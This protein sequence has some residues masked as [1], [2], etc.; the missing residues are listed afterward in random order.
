MRMRL[1]ALTT[2]SNLLARLH[3]Q[4]FAQAW[5]AESFSVLLAEAAT[6]AIFCGDGFILV[7]VVEGEAELLSLGVTPAARRRGIGAALL[8]EA[9]RQA[10]SRGA[11]AMFLEVAATNSP[12]IALYKR[13]GF[14]Q[15]GRRK[16]YYALAGAPPE[17]ALVLKVQIPPA[18]VGN[19]VQLG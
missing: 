6:F 5:S 15:I 10:A 19:T 9:L 18:P 12:A 13:Y 3:A 8:E 7:R 2:D 1:L 17:D 14:A 4:C 16:G 11:A